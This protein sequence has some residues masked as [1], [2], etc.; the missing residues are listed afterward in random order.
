MTNEAINAAGITAEER[1]AIDAIEE[2]PDRWPETPELI[3]NG[4]MARSRAMARGVSSGT[5]VAPTSARNATTS[6]RRPW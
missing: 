6:S 5:R 4:R 3:W 2:Q 1:A